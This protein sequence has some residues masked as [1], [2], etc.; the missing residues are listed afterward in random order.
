MVVS[1]ASKPEKV[2][3][4]DGGCRKGLGRFR[5]E[6]LRAGSIGDPAARRPVLDKT[7]GFG[8]QKIV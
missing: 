2:T 8:P 1:P 3:P 4:F 7:W 5:P 6:N